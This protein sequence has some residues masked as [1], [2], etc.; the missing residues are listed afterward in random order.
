MGGLLSGWEG[1]ICG[2]RL[3]GVLR[4][5]ILG[6]PLLIVL[7]SGIEMSPC[8]VMNCTLSCGD[9]SPVLPCFCFGLSN[10][11]GALL[12]K[13]L[14]GCQADATWHFCAYSSYVRRSGYDSFSRS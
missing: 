10:V 7:L 12:V 6:V 1:V 9:E 13:H 14:A 3:L 8:H 4:H 2:A 5:V 11:V